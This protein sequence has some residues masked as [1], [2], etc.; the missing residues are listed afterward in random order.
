MRILIKL[1]TKLI[2]RGLWLCIIPCFLAIIYFC[3]VYLVSTYSRLS[4]WYLGLCESFYR[5]EFWTTQFFTP[6]TKSIGN[7]YCSI[8]IS[9]AISGVWCSWRRLS[10]IKNLKVPITDLTLNTKSLIMPCLLLLLATIASLWGKSLVA[11]SND[12]VFSAVYCAGV[13]PFITL[14]YYMLPNNHIL[15]NLLNNLLFHS[16]TDKVA[17]GRVISLFAYWLTLLLAF[18]WLRQYFMPGWLAFLAALALALQFPLWGFSFQARGYELQAMAAWWALISLYKFISSGARKWLSFMCFACVW[19][20]AC[21]PTFLYFHAAIVAFAFLYTLK[22]KTDGLLLL[23]YQLYLIIAVFLFY[24]PCLCFSGS[25]AITGN[26]Y[27]VS[28]KTLSQLLS[29]TIPTAQNFLLYCFSLFVPEHYRIETVLFLLPLSLLF[30]RKFLIRCL[31]L[32]YM[33]M[34]LACIFLAVIM[35]SFPLDRTL[36]GQFSITLALCIYSIY[37]LLNAFAAKFRVHLLAKL[38]LPC[39][40]LLLSVNFLLKN[41]EYSVHYMCHFPVNDFYSVIMKLGI[42]EIPKG[43]TV[44]YSYETFF[45]YYLCLKNGCQVKRVFTGKEDYYVTNL[46]EP[47]PPGLQAK[48][49]KNNTVGDFVV[50]K[51]K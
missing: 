2:E 35:K 48:Y 5:K 3:I 27:V 12:E 37:I 39:I 22:H 42:L 21:V 32:F 49:E 45:W 46:Q 24:L 13:H 23:K 31:G 26:T 44:S 4:N 9:I 47:L 20:Y 28:G 1:N 33:L 43:S 19:G 51:L 6:H 17:S 25:G 18:Q 41:R 14:S 8:A 36:P 40:I 50:Y 38:V 30:N 10:R 16:F 11:P 29:E 34:W 15:F 7:I